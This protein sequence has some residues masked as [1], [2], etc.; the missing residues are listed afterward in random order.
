MQERQRGFRGVLVTG[1]ADKGLAAEQVKPGDL[2]LAVNNSPV[3]SASEF[4]LYLAASAAVQDT[5]LQLIRGEQLVRVKLS[6][7]PRQP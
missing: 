3:A 2:M 1:I 5:M 6:A 4:F 7:L